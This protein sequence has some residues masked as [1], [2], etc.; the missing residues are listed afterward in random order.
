MNPVARRLRP[1]L[2]ASSTAMTE[3]LRTVGGSPRMPSILQVDLPQRLKAAARARTIDD[4]PR[5]T[6]WLTITVQ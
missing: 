2:A 1:A 6:R 4:P 3:G 5:V